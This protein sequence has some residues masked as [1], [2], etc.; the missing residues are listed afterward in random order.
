LNLQPVLNCEKPVENLFSARGWHLMRQESGLTTE[1]I[2]TQKLLAKSRAKSEQK[3]VRRAR[4][5]TSKV[6]GVLRAKYQAAEV[7]LYGSLAWGGFSGHSDIDL[8]VVGFQGKY[9]DMYL[10]AERIAMPF[11]VCIVCAED[12]SASLRREV[13]DR[14]ES[15]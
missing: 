15:L 1:F 8:F 5:K 2:N 13:F 12:A 14:G 10:D 9:W 4:E 3:L 7:F 11:N 6:A